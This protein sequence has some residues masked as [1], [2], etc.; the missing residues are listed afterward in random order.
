MRYCGVR[1]DFILYNIT[2]MAF[3][4]QSLIVKKA[5]S[6]FSFEM[7]LLAVAPVIRLMGSLLIFSTFEK[8]QSK[9]PPYTTFPYSIIGK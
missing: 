5:V 7:L 4:L 6:P 9:D 8:L 3:S 2:R 1:E